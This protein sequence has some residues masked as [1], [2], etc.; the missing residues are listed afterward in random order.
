M[1]RCTQSISLLVGVTGLV[2]VWAG[3]ASAIPAF[4]REHNTECTTCHTIYPELNEYGDAF[5]KN[6]FVWTKH[7]K[8]EP[9]AKAPAPKN[10]VKGEGDPELLDQLK[11]NAL[12]G[13]EEEAAP[14]EKGVR[15]NESLWLA[16]LPEKLPLSI[17]AD[18]TVAYNEN[19]LDNDK[20]D[21]STRAVSLLAGGVFREKIGF[22]AK[23]D[24]FTQGMFNP[25]ISNTP[26]NNNPD[27][28]EIYFVWRKALNSPVNLKIG[29]F[30]PKL[31]LWKKSNKTS[32]SDF[33]TT[34][35]FVGNSLFAPESTEDALEAN[36]VLGNRVFV[37][38]GIVDRN[39]QNTKEGYGHVS[40]KFGGSDF[41]GK[42]PEVDLEKESVWDFL[43]VTLG[44]Y[45]YSG[46][47]SNSLSSNQRNNFLRSGVDMDL[48]YK[49]LRLRLA[50]A[51][52]RD[53]NPDFASHVK[54]ITT[55]LAAQAE[56]MIEV[57]LLGL[58]RYERQDSDRELTERYVGAVAYAPIENT[59]LTLEYQYAMGQIID[60]KTLL[61]LRFAF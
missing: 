12:K 4:S 27:I 47:N 25:A 31:S 58:F 37:A 10:V 46:R 48:L 11:E 26:A 17:S 57:N 51:Y 7:R 59:K 56:Y 8:D 35:F 20:L 18:L 61:G 24:L 49:S 21:L 52:G 3:T 54:E 5:L 19:A 22:F 34:S 41:L 2:V 38:G 55:V 60:R 13:V 14:A 23:Y 32:V 50:G 39:Q 42:E 53:L 29:R 33:A 9:E 45:G 44:A 36:A 28:E 6:G 16:G 1:S 43:S 30:R 15:K 40:V